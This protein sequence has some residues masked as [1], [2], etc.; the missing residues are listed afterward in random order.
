[1]MRRVQRSA[2]TSFN[3]Y[4][5]H[6]LLIDVTISNP[7][8]STSNTILCIFFFQAEDGIRDVAVTGVQTCALPILKT[9]TPP[10]ARSSSWKWRPR[11]CCGDSPQACGDSP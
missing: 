11:Q 5:T 9:S 1:M 10:S 7:N 6:H 4:L 3:T 2:D 8:L